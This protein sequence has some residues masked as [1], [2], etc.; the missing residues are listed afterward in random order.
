MAAGI[1]KPTSKEFW[2]GLLR[3]MRK[4]PGKRRSAATVSREEPPIMG[5]YGMGLL[6]A[7]FGFRRA[8]LT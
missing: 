2:E 4:A 3:E 8:R 7:N 5:E 1:S 6:T